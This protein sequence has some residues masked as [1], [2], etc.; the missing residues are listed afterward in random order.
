MR[1]FST[2]V[3]SVFSKMGADYSEL[4]NLM[5]DTV[6]HKESGI[7]HNDAE[8]KIHELFVNIAGNPDM[9]DKKSIRR[10]IRDK[11]RDMMDI[12]EDVLDITIPAGF[13]NSEWFNALVDSRNTGLDD[14]QKFYV[15][16]DGY[17]VV[18]KIGT[19]H[20]DHALQH[21]GGGTY[22][23][24]PTQRHGVAV[25]VELFRYL[26]GQLDFTALVAKID[27]AFVRATQIEVFEQLKTA[28]TK[29][30]VKGTK[31]INT[32]VLNSTS[33]ASF[34]EMIASVS[35]AN[36]G[37]D[38]VIAGT[39][40]ALSKLLELPDA[41][42]IA[43]SQKESVASTGLLGQYAG[44]KFMKID[45]R[46]TDRTFTD[47]VFDDKLLFVLPVIGEEGK[48]IKFVDAGDTEIVEKTQQGDYSNDIATYEVQR[49][50]G[51]ACAISRQFGVWTLQ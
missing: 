43:D 26:V 49:N 9:N 18:S 19:A 8:A 37:S 29:L 17:L 32:G 23:T 7:S 5:I 6:N 34:D 14:V 36:D 10:A 3:Q 21:F 38:V 50:F 16:R 35:M 2:N 45:N 24:V 13:Q 40:L 22:I 28:S 42:Y 25:G 11:S 44:H 33:K 41:R 15:P 51:V 48:F 31:F 27:E 4:K 30:P 1:F 46:F 12:L 20:H 47:T 39:E